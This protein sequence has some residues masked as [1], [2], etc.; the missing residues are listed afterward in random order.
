MP[1]QG[2]RAEINTFIQGLI[3]EASPL[4]FP[5]NASQEEENFV[6][7]RDGTRHRRLGLDYSPG[8]TF[9]DPGLG[10]D[11]LSKGY[12]TFIWEGA[13]GFPNVELLVVQMGTSV[14]FF[15]LNGVGDGHLGYLTMP[16]SE[17]ATYSF[18]AVEGKLVIAGGHPSVVMVSYI[19][20]VFSQEELTLKVRD[21]WGV[22]V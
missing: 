15:D 10:V 3:T 17:D 5:P 1:K 4:N 7:K 11:I 22:E 14:Y 9:R 21:F 8:N 6:L 12:N 19:S 2:Q 18:A 16:F 13:D 20:G